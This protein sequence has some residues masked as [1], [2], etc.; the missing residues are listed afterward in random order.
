MTLQVIAGFLSASVSHTE[1]SVWWDHLLW[2]DFTW[3]VSHDRKVAYV[4]CFLNRTETN[5]K[6]HESTSQTISL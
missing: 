5:R 4:Y 1:V 2:T 3:S 6:L